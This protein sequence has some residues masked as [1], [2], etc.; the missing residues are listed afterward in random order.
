MRIA[1]HRTFGPASLEH[2][3]GFLRRRY[4]GG[5]S[6]AKSTS[7]RAKGFRV[8]ISSVFGR[9]RS[10][11]TDAPRADRRRRRTPD[12]RIWGLL[13][14][15]RRLREAAP[16]SGPG[17]DR[18]AA[19]RT[20]MPCWASPARRATATTKASVGRPGRQPRGNSYQSMTSYGSRKRCAS[21][22]MGTPD[23]AVPPLRR[24][25]AEGYNVVGAVT[26]PRQTGRPRTGTCAKAT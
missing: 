8:R 14:L 26:D 6:G 9:Q 23:F 5:R 17:S 16:R 2:D 12:D 7:T 18:A 1:P 21:S 4:F 25:V 19:R 13:S 11:G 15:R 22:Y 10:A 24:L 20:A 3:A